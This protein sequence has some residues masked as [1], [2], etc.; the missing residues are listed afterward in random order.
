MSSSAVKT[1]VS[2]PPAPLMT[3]LPVQP[4]RVKVLLEAPPMRRAL[5]M[6]KR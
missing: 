2:V 6:L 5:S 1:M 4:V 3:A